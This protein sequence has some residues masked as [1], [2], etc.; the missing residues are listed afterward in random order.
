MR[1]GRDKER[2]DEGWAVTSM[3]RETDG[4]GREGKIREG[5][6]NGNAVG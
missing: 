1:K 4:K 2:K 5:E 3:G 6:G